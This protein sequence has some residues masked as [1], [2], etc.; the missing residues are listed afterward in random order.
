MAFA[1]RNTHADSV[2]KPQLN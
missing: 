1:I 2:S